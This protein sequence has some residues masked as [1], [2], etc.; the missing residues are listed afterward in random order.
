MFY[1]VFI[2]PFSFRVTKLNFAIRNGQTQRKGHILH[3]MH[4]VHILAQERIFLH[5][6]SKRLNLLTVDSV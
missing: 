2:F 1:M 4:S 3:I 5:F 6:V